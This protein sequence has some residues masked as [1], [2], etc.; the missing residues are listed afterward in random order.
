MK[1]LNESKNYFICS[2]QR[3]GSSYLCH[4]LRATNVLGRPGEIFGKA[5]A[6][7]NIERK[8]GISSENYELFAKE[9]FRH[10]RSSNGVSGVKVHYHQFEELV[11]KVRLGKIFPNIKFIF[12]D[13]DDVVAQAV[14]LYKARVSGKWS[15]DHNAIREAVYSYKEIKSCL[16][17]LVSEKNKWKA[18]FSVCGINPLRI[19]YEELEVAPERKVSLICSY[20]NVDVKEFSA[21]NALEVKIKKQ[22]DVE[23]KEWIDR[24]RQ[25]SINDWFKTND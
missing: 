19:S 20:L 14:S 3:S 4:L 12:I 10:W 11:S 9:V 6:I 8:I 1:A 16:D 13:R 25:D 2:T 21:E 23:T 18:F 7:S 22:R 24:F 5:K 15:S 17:I